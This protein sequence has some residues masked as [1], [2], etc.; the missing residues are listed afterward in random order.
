MG[1]RFALEAP[2][3]FYYYHSSLGVMFYVLL[4][5]KYPFYEISCGRMMENIKEGKYK[6]LHYFSV[7][8]KIIIR[9]L[10]NLDVGKRFECPLLMHHQLF[11]V[12]VFF[13]FRATALRMLRCSYVQENFVHKRDSLAPATPFFLNNQP[14]PTA[15]RVPQTT[16]EER[17]QVHALLTSDRDI[18]ASD[19]QPD[20]SNTTI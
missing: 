20:S 13:T 15:Q 6:M 19:N 1:F 2:F 5:Q 12:T 4:S 8:A 16:E 17:R 11:I 7:D 10:L 14:A 18:S 3:F 9:S